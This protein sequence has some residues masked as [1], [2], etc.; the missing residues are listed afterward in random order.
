M[1]AYLEATALEE[2]SYGVLIVRSFLLNEETML[3]ILDRL[4]L[5][6]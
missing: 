5:D 2:H 6:G 1:L 4:M 3:V